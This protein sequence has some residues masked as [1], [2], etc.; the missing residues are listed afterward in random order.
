MAWNPAAL[1]PLAGTHVYMQGAATYASGVFDRA[2]LDRFPDRTDD[3][4]QTFSSAQTRALSSDW[5]FGVANDFASDRVTLA[6]G[7]FT[8]FVERSEQDDWPG[9][10]HRRRVEWHHLDVP[11][12]ALAIRISGDLYVGVGFTFVRSWL[13]TAFD[14]DLVLEDP[15]LR[16]LG[17]EAPGGRQRVAVQTA[18]WGYTGSVGVYYRPQRTLDVGVGWFFRQAVRTTGAAQVIDY[19][20]SFDGRASAEYQMPDVVNAGLEWS[21]KPRVTASFALRYVSSSQHDDLVLRP[22]GYEFSRRPRRPDE[23]IVPESIVIDRG[24]NDLWKLDV[25]ASYSLLSGL[26]AGI[27]SMVEN[28]AVDER[29]VNP[30]QIDGPK[31]GGRAFA[32]FRPAQWFSIGAT[33]EITVMRD[34][35]VRESVYDP[36]AALRCVDSGYDVD[37]CAEVSEGR[38]LPD[39]RGRYELVSQ[40][41]LVGATLDRW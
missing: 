27:G 14:R 37:E 23:A 36:D 3:E 34:R 39:A 6:L 5:F 7:A 1:G 10:Y 8:P 24:F 9:A 25:A 35:E 15:D 20:G 2:D 31:V 32:V 22:S 40:R 29:R 13:H 21:P 11:S 18:G 12:F 33:W 19:D 28:S 4:P 16:P 17:Y 30:S 38:A 26:S 41:L